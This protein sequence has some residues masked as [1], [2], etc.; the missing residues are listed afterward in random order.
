MQLC[1]HL[2]E[3][4]LTRL[5]VVVSHISCFGPKL[6]HELGFNKRYSK[7]A[8]TALQ[9]VLPGL[10]LMLHPNDSESGGSRLRRITEKS[11]T[12]VF[13]RDPTEYL[14]YD[15]LQLNV[16][17]TGRLMFQLARYSKYR[18]AA[19]LS[20]NLCRFSR[21]STTEFLQLNLDGSLQVKSR[22]HK[23]HPNTSLVF[24]SSSD[25]K[26]SFILFIV[27]MPTTTCKP[28]SSS[29]ISAPSNLIKIVVFHNTRT[30][31]N[32][33]HFQINLVFTRD[34][35]ESLIYDV[36][37]L[38]VLHTGRLMFQVTLR[39]PKTSF[40]F[41]G[42]HQVGAVPEFPYVLLE[43]KFH[44]FREIY[45]FAKPQKDKT[46]RELSSTFQQP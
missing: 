3:E 35:T 23:P 11:F 44:C 32:Y 39:Q 4:I 31:L 29:D 28:L 36:L 37:Q 46:G 41:L 18:S 5:V 22:S 34:S 2:P 20:S 19:A 43:P 33:T 24:C 6:P 12:L 10:I 14:G 9:S 40:A 7:S 26:Y 45:S 21:K 30:L 16:P 17:H 13:T 25:T 15:V 42:V 38:N 1:A 8:S 27:F